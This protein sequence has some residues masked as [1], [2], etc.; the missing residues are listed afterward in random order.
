MKN[1]FASV[2]LLPRCQG[3]SPELH[4]RHVNI[5]QSAHIGYYHGKWSIG[6]GE[7]Q[8]QDLHFLRSLSWPPHQPLRVYIPYFF[9][10]ENSLKYISTFDTAHKNGQQILVLFILFKKKKISSVQLIIFYEY[11]MSFLQLNLGTQTGLVNI[12]L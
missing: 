3:I 7:K 6:V 8:T 12:F 5:S 9:C 1:L 4:L 11:W 2:F 10:Y